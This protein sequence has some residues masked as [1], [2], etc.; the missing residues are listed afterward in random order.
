MRISVALA[1]IELDMATENFH[2]KPGYSSRQEYLQFDDR[3]HT[4]EWQAEVYIAAQQLYQLQ[5]LNTVVDIG[6]GAA[7][8]LM[9][10]FKDAQTIGLDF[11]PN[12]SFLRE[13]YPERDWRQSDFSTPLELQPDLVIASDV[14]EHL[15]DPNSLMV[16]IRSLCP[17][18]AIVS[19]PERDVVRGEDHL[20]P[21]PNPH[22]VREWNGPE[23]VAYVNEFLPVR[24]HAVI[25]PTQFVICEGRSAT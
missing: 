3:P 16:Y 21:P 23:F 25:G 15:V 14:I 7:F 11:E 4:M 10:F 19:T 8:K 22:H 12:L 1:C 9:H 2:I 24:S 6:C 5:G 18:W 17:R 20:G 13:R